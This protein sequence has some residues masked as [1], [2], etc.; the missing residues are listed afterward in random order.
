MTFTYVG[1]FATDLDYIRFKINDTVEGSGPKPNGANYTDEEIEGL[2]ILE[3]TAGCTIAA[4]FE[5]LSTIY[6]P[7]VDTVMGPRSEKLSQKSAA[8]A[9]LAKTWRDEYGSST[10][11]IVVGTLDFDVDEDEDDDTEN[12]AEDDE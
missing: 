2:L 12:I 10:S 6:A 4:L 5:N 9:K 1:T 7:S 3:E 8:F 11:G